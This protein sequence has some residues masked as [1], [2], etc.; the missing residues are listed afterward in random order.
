MNS[1]YIHTSGQLV[2]RLWLGL[3]EEGSTVGNLGRKCAIFRVPNDGGNG[4]GH[5]DAT[6]ATSLRSQ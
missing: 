5:S 1:I 6:N 2:A 3:N 4:G